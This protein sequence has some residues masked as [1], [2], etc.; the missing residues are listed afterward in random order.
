MELS[1]VKPIVFEDK[2]YFLRDAELRYD[3]TEEGLI[4]K[5]TEQNCGSLVVEIFMDDGSEFDEKIFKQEEGAFIVPYTE[6][7]SLQGLYQFRFRA[8]YEDYPDKYLELDEPFNVRILDPCLS[9]RSLTAPDMLLNDLVFEYTMM[10]PSVE[11]NFPVFTPDPAWC[12][13]QYSY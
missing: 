5:N 3:W 12:D 11:L 1:L 10:T 6:D 4:M 7:T 9:P 8:Y 13:V 2:N